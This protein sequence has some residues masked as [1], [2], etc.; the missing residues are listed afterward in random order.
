M[1]NF[2]I[3]FILGVAAAT[4]VV[5][6]AASNEYIF[7]DVWTDSTNTLKIIGQ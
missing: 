1:K 3:G 5:A 2:I 7:N 4:A 6:Y